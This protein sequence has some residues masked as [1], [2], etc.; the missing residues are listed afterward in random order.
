MSFKPMTVGVVPAVDLYAEEL[1]RIA[2]LLYTEALDR[3]AE[4]EAELA[5]RTRERDEAIRRAD[6]AMVLV[7]EMESGNSTLRN[8]GVIALERAEKAEADRDAAIRR[9]EAAE[10][11]A[12]RLDWLDARCARDAG[13]T[14]MNLGAA[15]STGL[16][17]PQRGPFNAR[18]A[19]DAARAQE[20]HR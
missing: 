15:V 16:L 19:I 5:E 17:P 6:C 8:A 2:E 10:E 1:D 18:A 11:D 3:I 13:H 20:L 4:L 7:A 9:A 12:E 14:M